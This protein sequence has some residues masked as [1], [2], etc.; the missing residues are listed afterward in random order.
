MLGTVE[1][2]FGN[3]LAKKSIQYLTDNGSA[4]VAHETRWFARELNLEP[5]T[6]TVVSSPQ[7]NGMAEQFV[8]T[9]KSGYI[10]FMPKPDVR[11]ALINLTAAVRSSITMKTIHTVP[12]DTSR[13][14]NTGA[15]R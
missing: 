13:Q 8:K 7:S 9:M 6:T 11:M 5:C 2:W 10:T 12:R 1:K 14:W 15:S 3:Q 4:Y